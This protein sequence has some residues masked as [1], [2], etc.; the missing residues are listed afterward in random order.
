MGQ[1]THPR[2]CHLHPAES[3]KKLCARRSRQRCGPP[4]RTS[5]PKRI[6]ESRT[7]RSNPSSRS[8]ASGSCSLNS[9]FACIWAPV[10][11]TS[12][13]P[14]SCRW[15]SGW[16]A[17]WNLP[18]ACLSSPLNWRHRLRCFGRRHCA[19]RTPPRS[20]RPTA[21][22]DCEWRPASEASSCIRCHLDACSTGN[23]RTCCSLSPVRSPH[24]CDPPRGT[25]RGDCWGSWD[26]SREG[27]A[28]LSF[29]RHCC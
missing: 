26:W 4:I 24:R 20:A 18:L 22:A 25:C 1:I 21:W 8:A 6:A 9:C 5:A 16:W 17:F 23:R 12:T 14:Q 11:G 13:W 10:A 7:P 2:C 27:T 19:G 28:S 29:C 3:S 15:R